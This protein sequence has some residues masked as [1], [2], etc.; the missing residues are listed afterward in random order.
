MRATSEHNSSTAPETTMAGHTNRAALRSGGIA[1]IIAGL[2]GVT[3]FALELLPPVLGFDDTD[4]PAVSLAYLRQHPQFYAFAG[5]TLFIM[6]TAIFVASF[7]VSDALAPRTG[8]ITHRSLSA[9]GL[10]AAAFIFMHGV[11]RESVGPL[12][13]IETV[14][15][16]WGESAYLTIQMLGTHGFAPAGLIA[17]TAWGVCICAAGIR[18]HALPMWLCV[19]GLVA[20]LRLV[21]LIAGPLMTATTSAS[22]SAAGEW[23]WLASMALIPLGMLWWL[24]LGVVL[25]VES[26]PKRER[27]PVNPAE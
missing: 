6:A 18:S 14:D 27:R 7:A 13:Y 5:I 1:V 10:F 26:R 15:G 9:L 16:R 21:I 3:W 19:L 12:L 20:G 11:L 25:L 24:A 22:D 23:I 17:L 4:N 8:G 2:A